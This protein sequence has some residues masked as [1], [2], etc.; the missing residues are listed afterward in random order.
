MKQFYQA[1]TR[2]INDRIDFQ[3]RRR[4]ANFGLSYM[5]APD[6]LMSAITYNCVEK[7]RDLSQ[8]GAKYVFHL[9]LATGV[10]NTVD[11]L[12]VIKKLVYEDKTVKMADLIQALKANWVGHET[13]RARVQNGVPKFGND[14]DYVDSIAVRVLNDFDGY[15]GEWRRKQNVML[16]PVGVGTFE[17]YA[18]LGRDIG[19]SAD[20][21]GFGDPL[22]TN[23]TPYPGVDVQGPTAIIKSVTKPNLLRYY[24]GCPVDFS[25]N[26]N[27]VEGEAGID[28]LMGLITSFCDLGGQIMTITSTSV[29]DLKDAKI[30][31]E[32][33]KGLR[34]RMG[35]L[36]AYFIAMA[37]VQ[38]DNVIKR[39][40]R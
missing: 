34:V 8:N 24:C 6:P 36:S 7:G 28:R 10:S 19:A 12:A 3:C 30:H 1:Y 13:L 17:N 31:P 15:V 11:A 22:A 4:L 27:E 5:I 2:Q 9:I 37:P 29:E 38:Q 23:Y 25:I 16:F 21:R 18:V 14:D 26:A 20:G 33:H 40:A 35:G 32:R 39:F